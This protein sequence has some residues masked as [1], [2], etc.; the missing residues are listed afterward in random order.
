MGYALDPRTTIATL[1]AIMRVG[2]AYVGIAEPRY[3]RA[4]AVGY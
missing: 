2:D 3:G 4:G 1:N